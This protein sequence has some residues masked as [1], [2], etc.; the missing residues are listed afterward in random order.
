[1]KSIV[2]CLYEYIVPVRK[3]NKLIQ[4]VVISFSRFLLSYACQNWN[5]TKS[6]LFRYFL[7]YIPGRMVRGGFRFQDEVNGDYRYVIDH[8]RFKI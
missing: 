3:R 7:P 2:V 5:L 8:A 6:Q 1:M 4:E